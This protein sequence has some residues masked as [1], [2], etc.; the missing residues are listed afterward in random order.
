MEIV[1]FRVLATAGW[2]GPNVIAAVTATASLSQPR[3]LCVR[4]HDN[5]ERIDS[6]KNLLFVIM[7]AA[8]TA[9]NSINTCVFGPDPTSYSYTRFSGVVVLI[10]Y[11]D[12]DNDYL[13]NVAANVLL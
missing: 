3:K 11:L 7:H 4:V 8:V 13:H 9:H 6:Y 5:R 12:V 10:W 2:R 1:V